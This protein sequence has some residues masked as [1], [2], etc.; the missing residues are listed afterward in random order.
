MKMRF[1]VGLKLLL[2]MLLL[3]YSSSLFAATW[4]DRTR[5]IITER[6]REATFTI[7]NESERPA[8]LQLR[9]DNDTPLEI[10][11]KINT[12]FLLTPPIFRLEGKTSR[13]VRVQYTGDNYGA[14]TDRESL[15]WLNAL[16]VPPVAANNENKDTMQIAFRT[17]IKLYWRPAS[18]AK[19]TLEESIKKLKFTSVNCGGK[20]CLNVNNPTPLHITLFAISIN[21]GATP[22]Q[23]PNDGLLEPFSTSVIPFPAANGR[24]SD[25]TAFSWIDDYGVVQVHRR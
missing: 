3:H 22:H 2:L 14:A 11:E 12:P 6:D 9:T 8:L 13:T 5:L 16:E 1:V 15:F 23:L 25:V 10:P 7:Y 21:N 18:L 19:V 20:R 24:N 4:I 17:R